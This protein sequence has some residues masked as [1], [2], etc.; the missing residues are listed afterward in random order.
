MAGGEIPNIIIL[1]ND[2]KEK[3][4]DVGNSPKDNQIVIQEDDLT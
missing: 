1:G 3:V 2:L 4:M